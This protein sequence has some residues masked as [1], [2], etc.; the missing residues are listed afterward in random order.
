MALLDDLL[1][2]IEDDALRAVL[3]KEFATFRQRVNFGLVYEKHIPEV[4]VV[5]G[6]PIRPGMVVRRRDRPTDDAEFLVESVNSRSAVLTAVREGGATSNA[7]IKKLA[8]VKRFGD[9]IF[10]G[11]RSVRTLARGARARIDVCFSQES[12][13]HTRS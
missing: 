8:S 10:P 3:A 11:L 4:A 9:P 2:H 7:P 13:I 6:A 5:V 1:E 12:G